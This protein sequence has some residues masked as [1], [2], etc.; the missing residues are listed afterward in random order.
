[1]L[2]LHQQQAPAAHVTQ[3]CAVPCCAAN[4]PQVLFGPAFFKRHG[5]QAVQEAFLDFEGQFEVSSQLCRVVGRMK[6]DSWFTLSTVGA[7]AVAVAQDAVTTSP[8][9]QEW[10]RKKQAFKSQPFR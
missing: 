6:P 9:K 4:V 3:S 7:A 8:C 5:L 2:G 1:M 10:F